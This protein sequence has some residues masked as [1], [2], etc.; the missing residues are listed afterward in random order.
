MGCVLNL[1]SK[2]VGKMAPKIEKKKL[3]KLRGEV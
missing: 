1:K 3:G 2:S